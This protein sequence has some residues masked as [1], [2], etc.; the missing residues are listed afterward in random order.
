[1]LPSSVILH[2]E[3][4]TQPDTDIPCRMADYRLRMY[5]R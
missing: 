5:R 1:M 4:Q 2:L 3:F